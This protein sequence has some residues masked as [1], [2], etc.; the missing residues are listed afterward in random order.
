MLNNIA[1]RK[2][3]T[4][5]K[6]VALVRL[7]SKSFCVLNNRDWPPM[8][9]NPSPFAECSKM[10]MIAAVAVINSIVNKNIFIRK[11]VYVILGFRASWGYLMCVDHFDS[12]GVFVR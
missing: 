6:V 9:P 10:H 5:K 1:E 8:P 2:K 3:L 12:L 7:L 4:T 11:L